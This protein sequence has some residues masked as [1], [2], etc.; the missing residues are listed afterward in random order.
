MYDVFLESIM[1]LPLHILQS[2]LGGISP[3]CRQPFRALTGKVASI[4]W[5]AC[6]SEHDAIY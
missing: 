2:V 6:A 3:K 5:S 1:D 4:V